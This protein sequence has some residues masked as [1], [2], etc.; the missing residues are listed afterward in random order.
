MAMLTVLQASLT[1]IY[2]L[3]EQRT[4]YLFLSMSDGDLPLFDQHL[5]RVA[6]N[7]DETF[8]PHERSLYVKP[9]K[10]IRKKLREEK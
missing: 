10:P 2:P 1:S 8:F 4:A 9:K 6:C 5:E 3:S 7:P